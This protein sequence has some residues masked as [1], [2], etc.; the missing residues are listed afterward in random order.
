M[1]SYYV[2]VSDRAKRQDY[3]NTSASL[4]LLILILVLVIYITWLII[5]PENRYYISKYKEQDL[6]STFGKKFKLYHQICS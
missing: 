5:N 2:Y 1:D 6:I 3:I 4:G